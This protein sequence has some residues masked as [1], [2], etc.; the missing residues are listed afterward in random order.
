MACDNR[1]VATA[2]AAGVL[3]VL[4]VGSVFAGVEARAPRETAAF[5]IALDATPEAVKA[6]LD[7][8]Y[9]ECRS[10]RFVYRHGD[11]TGRQTA[12]LAINPGLAAHDPASLT[13]CAFSPAGDGI[14]DSIEARFAHPDVD[15]DRRLYSLLVFRE[16]PDVVYARPPRVRTTFAEV[17]KALFQTYGKPIDE[18]RE[19][20]ASA[21]ANRI[22]SLGLAGNV[23]RED[24]LVRYLWAVEGRLPDVEQEDAPCDCKARYVKA[25]IEIS[26][27]PSTI[28]ADA[29][30]VLSVKLQVEDPDLRARQDA[31]NAQRR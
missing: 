17:R 18:R 2:R 31:W 13:T 1:A 15:P 7:A 5:G 11:A 9:K 21:A 6:F 22:K 28:P 23:K 19:R 20:V 10:D 12:A 16:Y 8:R 3:A 26:R 27:S 24:Y 14:T 30:Y 4:F 25:V 29:F